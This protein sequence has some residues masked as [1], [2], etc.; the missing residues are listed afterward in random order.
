MNGKKN[1][2]GKELYSNGK[3]KYEGEFLDGKMH[4]KGREYDYYK[5]VTLIFEGEYINGQKWNGKGQ[6]YDYDNKLILEREY[7]NG[8]KNGKAREYYEPGKLKFEGEYLNDVLVGKVN[9]YYENGKLKFEGEING[10]GKEYDSIN[11]IVY[12]DNL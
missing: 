9:E 3:I 12:I 8:K 6:E 7:L 4:G 11:P 5:S 10:M 1:G 2:K